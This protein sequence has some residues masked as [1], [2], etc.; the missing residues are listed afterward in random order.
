MKLT[1]QMKQAALA[2][3]V[4]FSCDSSAMMPAGEMATTPS[5][6]GIT[7]L[8]QLQELPDISLELSAEISRINDSSDIILKAAQICDM[9]SDQNVPRE[10]WLY[11]HLNVKLGLVQ[12]SLQLV[13]SIAQGQLSVEDKKTAV[14]AVVQ[15]MLRPMVR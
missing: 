13:R 15:Q 4:C 8:S 7:S 9:F 12:T 3:V 2:S 11:S 14:F 5:V 10:P 6:R 1:K